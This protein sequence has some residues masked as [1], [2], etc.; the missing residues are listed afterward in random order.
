MI[1]DR[2]KIAKLRAG[3][4]TPD[5]M[6]GRQT[7]LNCA[8]FHGMGTGCDGGD[9]IDVFH[10]M[11]KFGLPDESCLHYAATDQSA[12]KEKGMERCPA[13]KFCVK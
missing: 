11:A 4:M 3:D 9:A 13:D 1:Q 5:V 6:L 12:F 8:A 7:L 10:Y 2:L